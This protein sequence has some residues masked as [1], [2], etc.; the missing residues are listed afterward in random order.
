MELLEVSPTLRSFAIGPPDIIGPP[1][2]GVLR[3]TWV[4][5]DN[6]FEPV[7]SSTLQP[8]QSFKATMLITFADVKAIKGQSLTKILLELVELV[9]RTVDAI[10]IAIR[11][12]ADSQR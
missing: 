5:R 10:E 6:V 3:K 1:P 8:D 11:A 7:Q 4:R 2:E 12:E 9:T